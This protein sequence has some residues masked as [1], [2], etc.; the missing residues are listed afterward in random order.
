MYILHKLPEK[1]GVR[2]DESI[3]AAI[4]AFPKKED[5]TYSPRKMERKVVPSENI[6]FC[7]NY[8]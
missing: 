1:K 5:P 8:N 7:S 6:Y 2:Y 3:E 4:V